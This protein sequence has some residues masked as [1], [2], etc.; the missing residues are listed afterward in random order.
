MHIVIYKWGTR[1]DF[2]LQSLFP[3]A[4][5]IEAEPLVD[6][7][8]LKSLAQKIASQHPNEV[9]HWFFQINLSYCE[10]WFD[11]RAKIIEELKALG[12]QIY[13][14][15]V[16]DTRK[17]SLQLLNQQL[18]LNTVLLNVNDQRQ[19]SLALLPVMVKSNY[20]FGGEFESVF[21]PEMA[22]ALGLEN[23]NG[24]LIQG[25]DGYFKTTLGQLDNELWQDQR[26]VIESYIENK[27]HRFYR[28]YRCNHHAILSEI[29]NTDVIKKMLPGS[30]RKNWYLQFKHCKNHIHQALIDS[31]SVLMEKMDLGFGAVDIVVDDYNQGYIIDVNPTPGWGSEQQDEILTFLRKGL[32]KR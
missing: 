23:I 21:A 26:L 24:C 12:F 3:A 2:L 9:L 20:N 17:R 16:T 5:I 6:D 32:D 14:A 15:D 10:R 1:A 27:S 19:E 28:F 4:Q 13:N 8:R 29:I 31:A 22:D 7:Q 11:N 30:V 18:A 25:Y